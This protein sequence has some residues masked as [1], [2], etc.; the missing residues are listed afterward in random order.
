MKIVAS[1]LRM[2]ASTG[3]RDVREQTGWISRNQKPSEGIEPVFHL[4]LPPVL[5]AA[6]RIEKHTV[7]SSIETRS[8]DKT[9]GGLAEQSF[10]RQK[11]LSSASEEVL[12]GIFS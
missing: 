5:V 10:S 3:Y 6:D 7:R 1:D 2:D 12:G 9:A 4:P 8:S 11:I